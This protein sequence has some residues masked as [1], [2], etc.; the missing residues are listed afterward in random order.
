MQTMKFFA[1][2]ALRL[3]NDGHIISTV[4]VRYP[5]KSLYH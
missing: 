3:S 1:S 2:A 4:V 5:R